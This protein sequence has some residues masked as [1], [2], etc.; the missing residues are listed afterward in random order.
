[1]TD[2]YITQTAAGA[3][4]GADAANAHS[5][6]WLNTSGN[7]A[8]TKV[9]DKIGPG[10]TV[11]L[12]GTIT[13]QFVISASGQADS[14]ITILFEPGAK[15]SA[16]YW[17]TGGAISLARR[18]YITIDGGATGTIGGYAGNPALANGIIECTDNGTA[19]GN[20]ANCVAIASTESEHFTIKNLVISNIYVRTAGTQNDKFG[21]GI[22]QQDT[23]TNSYNCDGFLVTN[24]VIHDAYIGINSD[25]LGGATDYEFSFVT[26]YNCNWG[27]TCHDRNSASSIDN[28]SVHDCWFHDWS[29]WDAA[30]DAISAHHNG[31]FTYA[32]SGGTIYEV[33]YYN[34]VLGPNFTNAPGGYN[35]S[36]SGLFLQANS[37]TVV[38]PVSVYNNIG[39]NLEGT[40]GPSNGVI[41]LSAH[42]AADWRV[43]NNTFIGGNS[44]NAIM[45]SNI[46]ET[47]EVSLT[48]RNNLFVGAQTAFTSL[49][50]GGITV[51]AD[52]NAGYSMLDAAFK[53]D[54]GGT[55]GGISL[56]AWQAA[57]G[58]DAD[59]LTADPLLDTDTFALGA[60]SPAIGAGADLSA[61]FTTDAA[62]ALRSTP[63]DIGAFRFG[64]APE[65][66]TPV[67]T[68]QPES[69]TVNA[70][71][72]VTLSVVASGVP[73]PTLQWQKN[74]V[75]IAGATSAT[76]V[77]SGV[78]SAD[79]G[80]Y[81]CV[82]TNTEGTATSDGAA[83]TV[84]VPGVAGIYRF[85]ASALSNPMVL[86]P[87]IALLFLCAGCSTFR[88]PRIA[89]PGVSVT[90]PK[91]AGKPATMDSDTSV[92]RF[93]IPAGAVLTVEKVAATPA[94]PK[95]AT[96]P[97]A[98]AVP[99]KEVRTWT[100]PEAS[101]YVEHAQKVLAT[102][103]TIDTSVAMHAADNAERRI[104]LWV[105]IVAAVAFVVLRGL[106]P[107]WPILSNSSGLIA[108]L[109]FAAWKFSEVPVWTLGAVVAVAGIA[110]FF[111]KRGEWDANGNGIPDALEKKATNPEPAK[112]S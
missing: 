13:D 49:Y 72:D 91:D 29:N 22:S 66:A 84:T 47:A 69:A 82:A 94:Q 92:S 4:T 39:L 59:F 36:T 31:W 101:A 79:A 8:S 23:I 90:A 33:R 83:L 105:A 108:A 88:L 11:H 68:A 40:H 27:G 87:C 35:A 37:G 104:L 63:W 48:M 107:A 60:G 10:D 16:P 86:L 41:A 106:V 89:I 50:K 103:G 57:T 78:Q 74:G 75:D 62:G 93:A 97:A 81:T 19:L 44:S 100:F 77:L 61:F 52:H 71:A 14:P 5:V 109:A 6:A 32:A 21:V 96:T 111:Y 98:P 112:T 76:L 99:A 7:W 110:V 46:N 80:T 85:A 34:N 17:P 38:G 56:A 18:A 43:N 15:M 25:F 3:D 51:T 55:G 30:G 53:W 95:T 67:I 1:M 2:F 45:V 20:Q 65:S 70:G 102:T 26:A 64:T 73:T 12:V 54:S 9:S 28:L 24:C 58:Q 42:T